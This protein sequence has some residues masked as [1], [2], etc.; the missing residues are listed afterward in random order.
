MK[1][2][3]SDFCISVAVNCC[4]LISPNHGVSR[5]TFYNPFTRLLVA[6]TDFPKDKMLYTAKQIIFIKNIFN[7]QWKFCRWYK[8]Y[9]H[10]VINKMMRNNN[11]RRQMAGLTITISFLVCISDASCMDIPNV[12][13]HQNLILLKGMKMVCFLVSSSHKYI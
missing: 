8:W 6:Q 13:R 2:W 5:Y 9:V 11:S 3:G 7:L 10:N 1:W 12:L 4:V